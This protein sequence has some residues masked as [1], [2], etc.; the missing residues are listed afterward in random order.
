MK[1]I[2]IYKQNASLDH[3]STTIKRRKIIKNKYF[4]YKTYKEFY[5]KINFSLMPV[6]QKGSI[7]ELGS[8]AGFIKLIIPNAITSDILK[9]PQIDMQFS[10]TNMPFKKSSINAFVII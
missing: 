7:V 5:K 1:D 2:Y 4:L 3:P 6:N 10:A 9:L 8:G